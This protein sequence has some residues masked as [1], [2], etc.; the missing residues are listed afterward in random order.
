MFI[1]DKDTWNAIGIGASLMSIVL[2][3]FS[4]AKLKELLH[5]QRNWFWSVIVALLIIS[6]SS[7]GLLSWLMMPITIPLWGFILMLAVVAS[8]TF[9]IYAV[10]NWARTRTSSP[11]YFACH[12]AKWLIT[13]EGLG[14]IPLCPTHLSEMAAEPGDATSFMRPPWVKFERWRCRECNH[15]TESWPLEDGDLYFDTLVRY[16]G[17]IRRDLNQAKI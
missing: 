6:A 10:I 13:S 16:K 15:R 11:R 7:L 4:P 12:G 5:R 14:E 17:Q 8:M 9:S 3:L 1:F 2:W